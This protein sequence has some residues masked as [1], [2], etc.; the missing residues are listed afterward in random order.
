MRRQLPLRAELFAGGDQADAKNLLPKAVDEHAGGEGIVFVDEPMSKGE[1]IGR[2]TFRQRGKAA[3]GAGNDFVAEIEVI[4]AELEFRDAPL[5]FGQFA[6]NG[7]D[8]RGPQV[9]E[10]LFELRESLPLWPASRG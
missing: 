7:R 3:G 2:R 10:L 9:G 1:A 8:G 5:A 4:T 6:H